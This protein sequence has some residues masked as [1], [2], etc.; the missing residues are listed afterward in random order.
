[1]TKTTRQLVASLVITCLAGAARPATAAEDD[2]PK[3]QRVRSSHPLITALISQIVEQSKTFRGLIDAVNATDGMVYLEKGKC[4]RGVRACLVKVT[5]AA[6]K[7]ILWVKVDTRKAERALLAA[8]IGHELRHT[9]EVLDDRNVTD[10][11]SLYMFYL[12]GLG[13]GV[14]TTG[15][16][17]TFETRA[18]I[19]AGDAVLSEVRDYASARTATLPR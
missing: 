6:S 17:G 18:A 15:T 7:R 3:L 8:S 1:M 9:L 11:A 14:T 5:M 12:H 16:Q 10:N 13:L 2:R 4:G 19:E